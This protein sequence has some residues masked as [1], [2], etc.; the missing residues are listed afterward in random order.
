MENNISDVVTPSLS[1]NIV[2]STSNNIASSLSSNNIVTSASNAASN[3]MSEIPTKSAWFYIRIVL[4][5]LFLGLMGLNIFTYLSE[6][7][8]IFGKY[9][10]MGLLSG[11]E[12]TKKTL[13][14]TAAGG[15]LGVDVAEGSVSQLFN[16]PEQ[17]IRKRLNQPQKNLPIS[18]SRMVDA[19]T[20]GTI[21]TNKPAY[22]YIGSEN[23]NR[24]C[25]EIGK[26][27]VCESNKVFPS[28]QICIN[29]NLR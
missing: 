12:K 7:T 5:V 9:L 3:A 11:I 22:C 19:S 26:D 25:V 24:R 4:I 2:T 8:D 14:V 10:G 21:S 28:M 18:G 27:D 29:P 20:N 23:G 1:N 13:G 16:I 17:Q 15:K 6:G